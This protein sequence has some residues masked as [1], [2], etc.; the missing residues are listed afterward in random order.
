[1]TKAV[2]MSFGFRAPIVNF[3]MQTPVERNNDWDDVRQ[4]FAFRGACAKRLTEPH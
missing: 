2:R 1:M 4:H 3:S